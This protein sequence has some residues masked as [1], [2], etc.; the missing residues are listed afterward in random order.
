MRDGIDHVPTNG[1]QGGP[2]ATPDEDEFVKALVVAGYTDVLVL[3]KET[4]ESVLT[5]RRLELLERL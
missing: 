5:E 1:D 3:E 2:T 4:A